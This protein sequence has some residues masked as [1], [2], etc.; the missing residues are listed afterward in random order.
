MDM[1]EGIILG[2]FGGIIAELSIWFKLR[3]EEKVPVYLKKKR[4]WIT[5][6]L[7]ILTGGFVVFLYLRSNIPLNPLMSVHVGASAPLLISRFAETTLPTEPG[8]HD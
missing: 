5:T 6:I 7:M 1:I 4:Y 2:I 8:S 3:T